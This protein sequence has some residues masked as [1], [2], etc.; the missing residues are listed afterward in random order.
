MQMFSANIKKNRFSGQVAIVTGA[1]G[2]IGSGIALRLGLE[3]ATVVLTDYS[4][5]ALKKPE[6]V[7]LGFLQSGA[8]QFC[9]KILSLQALKQ[10]GIK[11]LSVAADVTKAADVSIYYFLLGT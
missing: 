3:G 7:V 9:I 4:V 10:R 6:Q 8:A 11:T 1:G 5:D 2:G